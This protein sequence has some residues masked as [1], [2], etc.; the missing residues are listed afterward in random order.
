MLVKSKTHEYAKSVLV[1]STLL[2]V[3]VL[4][5]IGLIGIGNDTSYS[6]VA[7]W[8]VAGAIGFWL[9]VASLAILVMALN[10]ALGNGSNANIGALRPGEWLVIFFSVVVAGLTIFFDWFVLSWIVNGIHPNLVRQTVASVALVSTASSAALCVYFRLPWAKYIFLA[11]ATLLLLR[12]DLWLQFPGFSQSILAGS[13]MVG[14]KSFPALL[15]LASFGYLHR[16]FGE[17]SKNR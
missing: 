16:R 6:A 2:L 14:Y 8:Y 12:S 11:L 13:S 15:A 5:V 7:G 9:P 10:G 1:S 3:V 17:L 4:G